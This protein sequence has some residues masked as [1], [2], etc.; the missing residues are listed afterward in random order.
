MPFGCYAVCYTS[1]SSGS[2]RSGSF[3]VLYCHFVHS[4]LRSATLH[5]ARSSAFCCKAWHRFA[6]TQKHHTSDAH[7]SGKACPTILRRVPF[8]YTTSFPHFSSIQSTRC[9][10]LCSPS[11][12]ATASGLS[13]LL[14]HYTEPPHETKAH[15]K[16]LRNTLLSTTVRHCFVVTTVA[17]TRSR[18]RYS[19]A[20]LSAKPAP[21][22]CRYYRAQPM[23]LFSRRR[24]YLSANASTANTSSRRI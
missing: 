2:L 9:L 15:A 18:L 7:A 19:S 20:S 16:P 4:V 6:N 3:C 14:Y 8:R 11:L 13:W 24:Y 21:L 12:P 22:Q 5:H 23:L 1:C 10:C 17:G